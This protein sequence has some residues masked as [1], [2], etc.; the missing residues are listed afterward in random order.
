MENKLPAEVK[1]R[2]DHGI[3]FEGT[4]VSHSVLQVRFRQSPQW[5]TAQWIDNAHEQSLLWLTWLM[6]DIKMYEKSLRWPRHDEKYEP[7]MWRVW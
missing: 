1:F 7:Y 2:G 3:S 4:R 5:K 6:C